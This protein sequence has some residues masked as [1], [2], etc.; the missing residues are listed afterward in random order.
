[1]YYTNVFSWGNKVYYRGCTKDRKKHNKII[2]Y[3]P[4]LFIKSKN[5]ESDIRSMKGEPLEEI[6]FETIR[7]MKSFYNDY[8]GMMKLY[9][10][11]KP[12]LQ[13][14][15]DL[16]PDEIDY[17]FNSLKILS[18]DIETT[19]D[20]GPPNATLALEE[21]ILIT[22][23]DFRTKETTTFY[24]R[25]LDESKFTTNLVKCRNEKDLLE[26]FISFIV[27]DYPDIFTGYNINLFD[28]KYIINRGFKLLSESTVKKLSP[29]KILSDRKMEITPTKSEDIYDIKGIEILD[30]FD[31]YKKFSLKKLEN[32]KLD[33]VAKTEL[34]NF[35]KLENP[36]DSFKDFI[37]KD[38]TLF[39]QYN[40]RDVDIIDELE[41]QLKMMY[42]AVTIAYN[43]KVN[44]SDVFSPV[45]TWDSIIYNELYK[46]GVIA[47]I[48]RMKTDFHKIVGA[49]VKEPTPKL[50]KDVCSFDA[51]S[52]YP[53]IMM[54]LNMSPETLYDD[55]DNL[56]NVHHSIDR[57][58]N[59]EVNISDCIRSNLTIAANGQK[60]RKDISGIFITM[61]KK[62]FSMRNNA[63]KEMIDL[64]KLNSDDSEILKKI[65]SLNILQMACK[66]LL[67]SLYGATDNKYFRFFDTRISEGVTSTGQ[68]IIKTMIK[69]LNE[70]LQKE[71]GYEDEDFVFYCDTD[72]IY[73]TTE[74]ILKYLDIEVNYDESIEPLEDICREYLQ[75]KIDSICDNIHTR[76]NFIEKTIEFKREV[77][78]NKGVWT[79]KKRYFLNVYNSEGVSYNPP[80]LKIMGMD[81]ARSSTQEVVK[82]YLTTIIKKVI[83]SDNDDII[84]YIEG[85]SENWYNLSIQ[86]VGKPVRVNTLDDYVDEEKIYKKGA[87]AQIKA[88]L[89][90]NHFITKMGLAKKY[91]LIKEGDSIK[92]MY[93]VKPNPLGIDCI[94]MKDNI[95]PKEF[96]L[97]DF[98]DYEKMLVTYFLNPTEKILD[99]IEWKKEK[100]NT[101]EEM[102]I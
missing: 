51:K 28:I 49:Y 56:F 55:D 8:K 65:V 13:F 70:I 24:F 101:L 54:G 22:T 17:D 85:I 69:E 11:P 76:M 82:E 84:E 77:I 32:Y 93:L 81:T 96:N 73:I 3:S 6:T 10:N 100:I 4:T 9:G 99:A 45:N 42:V 27:A 26:K 61:I 67:N 59:N 102:F 89:F 7:E 21:I 20:H 91:D 25:D 40:I 14:I 53:S 1:M 30:Y 72:G 92:Y 74:K 95:L 44:F 58:V 5:K 38:F 63:K 78:A 79:A 90:H 97:D 31:L 41:Q 43:A 12:Y 86:E 71:T 98:I 37:E 47:E 18:I 33:T 66:I 64:E 34:K 23:K 36:Y 62:F 50:Y 87:Q 46:D 15:T 52:L 39:T 16:F 80:K 48:T 57:F 75:E 94:G 35:T 19:V 83:N 88:S 68:V 2:S 60:F 29:W